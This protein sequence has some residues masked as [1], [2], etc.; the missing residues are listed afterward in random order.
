MYKFIDT[1]ERNNEERLPSEAMKFNGVY[2]EKEIPG[3]R[4]LQVSGREILENELTESEVG[5]A[6]GARLRRKRYPPRVITVKYCL[7]SEDSVSFRAAYNKLNTILDAEN[8]QLIFNDEL[9]KYF[10]GTKQGASE[11]PAGTNVVTGEIEFLCSD[12]FKYAVNEKTVLPTLDDGKTIVLDYAGSYKCYPRII[13]TANGDLEFVGYVNDQG[14]VLQIGDTEE[15]DADKYE[16]SQV[17]IDDTHS[18][19]DS[20]EWLDNIAK[21]TPFTTTSGALLSAAQ[22]GSMMIT[23]DGYGK[24]ILQVENYGSGS[25]FHGPSITR[26][27]PADSSGHAGAKNCTLSWHHL[28]EAS[29]PAEIGFVQFLMTTKTKSGEK[30]NVAGINFSKGGSSGM[31]ERAHM[32]VDGKY[33][34]DVTFDVRKGNVI[35]GS[36]GGRSSISKFGGKFTFNIAGRIY[37]FNRPELADIEVHEVSIYIGCYKNVPAVSSN[38]VYSVRFVSHSVD[39][40]KDVPNKFGKKDEIVADCRSGSVHVNGVEVPGIGA[41]GNDWEEFYLRPGKNQI[42]C[43]YSSWSIRPDFKLKYREV[44]L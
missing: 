20:A 11:V 14:R 43:T 8:A 5:T 9:D 31:T 36:K 4:T 27:V 35:T 19:M 34:K 22:S 12:P 23:D 28:F 3:Y 26:T 6:D 24:N 25:E 39:A 13:S 18:G 44:Y 32:Y 17:L 29:S 42:Q 30:K 37:E 16:A 41:V 21:N 40:W 33:Q 7:K 10:V 38:G 2:L 1:I 15:V